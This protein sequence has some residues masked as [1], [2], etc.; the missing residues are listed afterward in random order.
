MFNIL[1]FIHRKKYN[2]YLI[3]YAFYG[4]LSTVKYLIEKKGA[5]INCTD[6]NGY[7]PLMHAV[8]G[9]QLQIIK[10]LI[11]A[12]ADIDIKN[13][14]GKTVLDIMKEKG[15]S[16]VK[17]YFTMYILPKMTSQKAPGSK[18]AK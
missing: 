1:N 17:R 7:T 15:T 4:D 12:G 16:A 11:E 9:G 5:N 6:V 8:I 10:Y 14:Y 2:D 13:T 3:R 18:I